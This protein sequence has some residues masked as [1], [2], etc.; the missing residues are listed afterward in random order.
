MWKFWHG[1]QEYSMPF[2]SDCSLKEE[3]AALA[4]CMR[5][6]ANETDAGFCRDIKTLPVAL[7]SGIV[8]G[9]TWYSA[10]FLS[11]K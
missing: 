5:V 2:V 7:K 1:L 10:E 4:Q 8:C 9:A 6:P 11:S 3:K